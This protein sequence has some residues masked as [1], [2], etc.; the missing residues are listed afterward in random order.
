QRPFS[1]DTLLFDVP[2]DTE[3]ANSSRVRIVLKNDRVQLHDASTVPANQGCNQ[4]QL[5]AVASVRIVLKNDRVQ[6][7]DA[8]TVP[9]NQGCNQISNSS[10]CVRCTQ[11]RR[12][13]APSS[14]PCPQTE[15]VPSGHL[16]VHLLGL[17]SCHGR[18]Y[19]GRLYY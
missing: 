4:R 16:D 1:C 12:V 17:E 5:T 10:Q 14:L 15:R 11:E 7:K 8:S 3:A 6:L 13:P 2:Y 9:A 19:Y 18:L